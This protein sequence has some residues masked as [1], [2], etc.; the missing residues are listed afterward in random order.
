MTVINPDEIDV[1]SPGPCAARTTSKYAP[2]RRNYDWLKGLMR[3]KELHT[4]CEEAMCP[5]IASAG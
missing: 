5:N 1:V 2:K 3:S 4:V